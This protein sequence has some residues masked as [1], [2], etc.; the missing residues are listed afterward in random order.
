M[1]ACCHTVCR[2]RTVAALGQEESNASKN[3]D[4]HSAK[5]RRAVFS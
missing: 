1:L 3:I 2:E 4:S 5:Q